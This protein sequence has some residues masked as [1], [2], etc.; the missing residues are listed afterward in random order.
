M[1]HLDEYGYEGHGND[2]PEEC[3]ISRTKFIH[4]ARDVKR[5]PI[6]SKD[7]ATTSFD[8]II[9][10]EGELDA[11]DAVQSINVNKP[12]TANGSVGRNVHA[13]PV[14]EIKKDNG[15]VGLNSPL[16]QSVIE[17]T[18]QTAEKNDHTVESMNEPDTQGNT[19]PMVMSEDEPA[20]QLAI[21]TIDAVGDD[22]INPELESGETNCDKEASIES[23]EEENCREGMDN[24]IKNLIGM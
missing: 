18:V 22:N 15:S 10:N 12:N 20:I 11:E 9:E 19:N 2:I 6:V 4:W 13:S 24:P 7:L 8:E 3:R 23:N 17:P 5:I 1:L 21:E 16:D 14:T